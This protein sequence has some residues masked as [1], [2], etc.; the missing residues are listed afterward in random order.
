MKVQSYSDGI[1]KQTKKLIPSRNR[2]KTSK[3]AAPYQREIASKRLSEVNQAA[4][5]VT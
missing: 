2:T 5:K 4:K 3:T 1:F